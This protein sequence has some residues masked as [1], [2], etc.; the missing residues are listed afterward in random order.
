MKV[1]KR[2]KTSRYRG[3]HTHGRGFKKKARG[4]G[5]RGGV[6]KAGSGKRA[7]HKKNLTLKRKK[8]GYFGKDKIRR[9]KMK[10]EIKIITLE[11]I[12]ENKEDF[13]KKGLAKKTNDSYD[14]DLKGFKII[15]NNKI[16]SKIKINAKAASK[17]AVESI[18]KA[19]GEI[20]IEVKNKKKAE[21]R[22][23]EN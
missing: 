12:N 16:D 4:S 18:K 8:K 15:G 14:F 13:I 7:D 6:G 10:E 3:S 17:G 19:G 23:S 22:E 21:K 2:K 9:G 20:V 5:H 11:Q 1:K